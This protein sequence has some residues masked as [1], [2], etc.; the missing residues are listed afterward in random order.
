[1]QVA[2][3]PLITNAVS[4]GRPKTARHS[5]PFE[6]NYQAY[7]E[8]LKRRKGADAD[9]ARPPLSSCVSWR[10][11]ANRVGWRHPLGRALRAGRGVAPLIPPRPALWADRS[12]VLAESHDDHLLLP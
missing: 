2:Y 11:H 10:S 3:E 5:G 7:I 8:D 6:G 1:M 4:G 9:A 12:D